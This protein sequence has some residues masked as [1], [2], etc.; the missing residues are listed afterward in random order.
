[1]PWMPVTASFLPTQQPR[2][3]M[4]HLWEALAKCRNQP[5]PESNASSLVLPWEFL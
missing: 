5:S 1:M 4:F 3:I 2:I